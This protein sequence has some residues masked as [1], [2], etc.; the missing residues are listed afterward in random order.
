MP[1]VSASGL[2]LASNY[3]ASRIDQ[4]SF[5]FLYELDR[6]ISVYLIRQPDITSRNRHKKIQARVLLLR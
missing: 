4:R 3:E 5:C 1:I 6:P 2:L